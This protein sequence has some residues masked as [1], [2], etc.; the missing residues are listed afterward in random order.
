MEL[1]YNGGSYPY[2][3]YF[4]EGEYETVDI[5]LGSPS[6]ELVKIWNYDQTKMISQELYVPAYVF[7]IISQSKYNY[8]YRKNIVI[9]AVKDFFNRYNFP[10]QPRI[11]PMDLSEPIEVDDSVSSV[12]NDS[13]IETLI[14][15]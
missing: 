11:L 5:E 12:E 7:P 2:Y 15:E 13:L 8:F 9:P 1:V 10:G 4:V 6:L 14:I 3:D